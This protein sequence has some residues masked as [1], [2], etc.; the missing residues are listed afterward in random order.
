MFRGS[1]GDLHVEIEAYLKVRIA[2]NGE[3]QIESRLL[4]L[5]TNA[6]IAFSA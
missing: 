2:C 3:A 1:P 5:Q 6:V 4:A